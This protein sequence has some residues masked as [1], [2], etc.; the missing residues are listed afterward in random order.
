MSLGGD[1]EGALRKGPHSSIRYAWNV[2]AFVHTIQVSSWPTL[3]LMRGRKEETVRY[4][5]VETRQIYRSWKGIFAMRCIVLPMEA[6]IVI[7][8]VDGIKMAVR[9]ARMA[10]QEFAGSQGGRGWPTC[11]RMVKLLF[12][13]KT[14]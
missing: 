10:Q 4:K 14:T 8:Q 2:D 6:D 5:F 11:R 9:A 3:W 1:K 13:F 12:F 7:R